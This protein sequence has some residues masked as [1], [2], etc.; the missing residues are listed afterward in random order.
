MGVKWGIIFDNWLFNKI[1][2][3]LVEKE[4]NMFWN[5]K[6]EIRCSI[7]EIA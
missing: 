7:R 5:I 6:D 1:W 2:G 3:D 4:Y